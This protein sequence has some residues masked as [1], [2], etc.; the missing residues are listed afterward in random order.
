ME[1]D[2]DDTRDTLIDVPTLCHEPHAS[3]LTCNALAGT[4]IDEDKALHYAMI[5]SFQVAFEHSKDSLEVINSED[6]ERKFVLWY[7]GIF[8]KRGVQA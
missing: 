5:D 7:P 2:C 1:L 4:C 3:G 8:A 6:N